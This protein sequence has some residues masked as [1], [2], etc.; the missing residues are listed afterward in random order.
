[1]RKILRGTL[2]LV[3][4]VTMLISAVA[5]GAA[6]PGDFPDFPNDWSTPALEA[7]LEHGL[8]RGNDA[9]LLLPDAYLTRAEM[10][11]II[12][13]AFG[14]S[15][16]A[17]I[18]FVDVSTEDWF[19]DDIAKAVNMQTFNGS[20]DGYMR[21][22]DPITRQEAFAVIARAYVISGSD[23]SSLA[24]FSDKDDVAAWAVSD[25][26]SLVDS[27]YING[28]IN[29]S[30]YPLNNITR[31]EFA[32]VMY[33]I[34]QQYM[35]YEGTFITV[36]AGNVMVKAPNVS[37][38]NLTV[39]GDLVIGDGAGAGTINLLN[40]NITGR[41]VIRG[42]ETVTL[43]N[44]TTGGGVIVKNVNAAVRF[45][46]YE[47]E[48]VFAGATYYT[49]VRFKDTSSITIINGGNSG[50]GSSGSR[51]SVYTIE[52]YQQNLDQT[53]Y[54]LYESE[55]F[56]GYVGDTVRVSPKSYRGFTFNQDESDISGTVRAG[57]GLTLRLYY[58]RNEYTITFDAQGGTVDPAS[59]KA[60]YGGTITLP[61][62]PTRAGYIFEGWYT[63]LNGTG[64]KIDADYTV[65]G[66][67][68][69]YAHWTA[70]SATSYTVTFKDGANETTVTVPAGGTV[71]ES[72]I[73]N[74]YWDGYWEGPTGAWDGTSYLHQVHQHGWYDADGNEFSAT[75]PVN[76]NLTVTPKWK[77]LSV[78]A[79][80]NAFGVSESV[81]PY[82]MYNS[83][84]R[85]L[86]SIKDMIFTNKN[87]VLNGIGEIEPKLL[88]KAI[89]KGLLDADRNILKQAQALK[90]AD[91]MGEDNL[92]EILYNAVPGQ[93]DEVDDVVN[94]LV[95]ESSLT[96]TEQNH[97][98]VVALR[99]ELV[100]L[101][102]EE[103]LPYIPQLYKDV[104]TEEEMRTLFET[105]KADY[106]EMI[107]EALAIVDPTTRATAQVDCSITLYI[108]PVSDILIP[109]YEEMLQKLEGK[110]DLYADNDAFI[111]LIA[112]LTPQNLLSGSETPATEPTLSGYTLL[113]NEAYY[114]LLKESAVLADQAI[115]T[116]A[117]DLESGKL[118]QQQIDELVDAFGDT[119]LG[120]LDTINE[121][122][123]KLTGGE[124]G[125]DITPDDIL[126][127]E[128]TLK[129]L[130]N[131]A[132]LTTDE[133]MD[134]YANGGDSF[135]KQYNDNTV[136][137]SRELR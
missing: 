84:T 8:L 94:Q 126:K 49:E 51:R 120:Y 27:G 63:G 107:D 130:L 121:F 68:T 80:I 89:E 88:E 98:V 55:D 67:V 78:L 2:S 7:A 37:L 96:V 6:A 54:E 100:N 66:A 50:S 93:N 110:S 123:H 124:F 64:T 115:Q 46:N 77:Q 42:G 14:A 30:L 75:T 97:D 101:T 91:V 13:R 1:M 81:R 43:T 5:V 58:D 103:V 128:N 69:L 38:Q 56:T 29:G 10:A 62:D 137:V 39:N 22:N 31:A 32:Q 135:T 11:A 95:N 40:V 79:E 73:P 60:L 33:N 71:L 125:R 53:E 111:A 76:A 134:R 104:M 3:L 92:R 16:K 90:I 127:V 47:T 129:K 12:N 105:S 52:Y 21:P 72:D 48:A 114:E 28:D 86:D 102:F 83:D 112:L 59:T 65:T 19:Y 9:G 15:Q 25:V 61:A 132:D 109:K 20:G 35:A 118:T 34:T 24:R 57:G 70:E 82:V 131:N 18:N 45:N 4:A 87:L 99:G 116:F 26:A 108:N 23:E 117:D 122:I 136:T 41:L 36:G 44:V 85:L 119:L 133:F 74:V 113:S 106:L 17:D